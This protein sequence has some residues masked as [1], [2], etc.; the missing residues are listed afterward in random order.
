MPQKTQKY[1]KK[2]KNIKSTKLKVLSTNSQGNKYECLS[3][4]VKSKQASVFMVQETQS[5]KK[6]KYQ[7]ENYV[8]FEAKRNKVGGGSLLGVHESMNP[9]LVSLYEVEFEL[10]VVKTKVGNKEIRF[11]T[12]YGP[13][14][15]WSD[16]LKAPFFV[17]LDHEI[18]NAQNSNK[19]VF[20]AMDAN[21]KLGSEYIP[22]DPHKMSKNGE[23]LGEIVDRN[24]LIVV[25]GLSRCE[26]VITR[27]RNTIDGRKEKSAIDLV[28]ISD[29]LE[30]DV[31]SLKIDETRKDVLTKI[32]KNNKGEIKKT[33]SDHNMLETDLNI[34]WNKSIQKEKI[35]MYN[36]KNK[37]CQQ[38]FKELT[39]KTNMAS[40]F[41][42]NKHLD[43][44]TK[45]F[46]KRLNGAI[47]QC[48]KKIRSTKKNNNK[49]EVMYKKLNELK[50]Q[51]DD[52]NKALIEEVEKQ[53]AAEAVNI[54]HEETKGLDSEDGGKNPG[55]L[56]NLNRKIIPKTPQVPSAM[57]SENGEMLFTKEDIK[58]HTL[59]HYENVLRNR[60]IQT[61]LKSHK[62]EREELCVLR[63]NETKLNKTPDWTKQD[64]LVVLKGLKKKKSRDP[65]NLAN[66]IFDPSVAGDDLID[67]TLA[68]MN[69]IK[70]EGV[71]PKCMQICNITSLYKG[72]GPMN[73]YGSHRGAYSEFRP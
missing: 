18:S 30:K 3:S 1:P 50:S 64:L 13:Q 56:W 49:L 21:C 41:E 23:I 57:K 25:N 20:L 6:G 54:I 43:V 39:S 66:E 27:E 28:I 37:V 7:I 40:I 58:K 59:K 67:A 5:R 68:L 60:P 61:E 48:F 12:G 62:K 2:V 29:D 24:A 15:D 19:S 4:L 35:E 51:V 36:L 10:I 72:K 45:K 73:K 34:S 65:N 14:E 55:H 53:I 16:D 32:S 46:L 33:E 63:L 8:I 47:V 31:L 42:S 9:L 38:K 26:G 11:I 71:Y 44:L 70:S 17:A 52:E 22:K 69:K